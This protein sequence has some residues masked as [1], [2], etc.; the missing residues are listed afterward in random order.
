MDLIKTAV[1]TQLRLLNSY[2][3]KSENDILRILKCQTL[4]R[5]IEDE[6]LK[7]N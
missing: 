6:I 2:I 3:N 1:E 5:K 4:L 7:N